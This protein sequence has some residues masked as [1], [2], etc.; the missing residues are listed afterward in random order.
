MAMGLYS[1]AEFEEDIRSR[2]GL[3]ATDQVTATAR[4][5]KTSGGHFIT[6]PIQETYPDYWLDVVKKCIEDSVK[7]PVPWKGKV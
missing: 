2:W 7:K 6:I 1:R 5:W 3:E 4:L